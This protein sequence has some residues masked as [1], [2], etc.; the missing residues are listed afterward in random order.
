MRTRHHWNEEE[1]TLLE[2]WKYSHFF[3][4]IR[5]ISSESS[6]TQSHS[7]FYYSIKYLLKKKMNPFFFF[8][9]FFAQHER[10]FERGLKDLLLQSAAFRKFAVTTSKWP[11]M[12]SDFAKGFSGS[13]SSP[14]RHRPDLFL[15]KNK[16]KVWNML[17]P[18]QKQAGR[19]FVSKVGESAVRQTIR[20]TVTEVLRHAQK[21]LFK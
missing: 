14:V 19:R 1:P 17:S 3:F 8:R 5:I 4:T 6:Q 18:A 12:L 7:R 21:K 11:Q 9:T 2:S 16:D 15:E 13:S 10:H 20:R